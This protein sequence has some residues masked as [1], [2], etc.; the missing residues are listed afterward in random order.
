M[1]GLREQHERAMDEL[2]S[3]EE[4][5]RQGLRDRDAFLRSRL[6]ELAHYLDRFM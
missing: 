6:N 3:E 5:I 2:H 1:D 4:L